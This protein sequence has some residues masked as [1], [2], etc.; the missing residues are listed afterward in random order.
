MLANR[1]VA[2]YSLVDAVPILTLPG[3]GT[4]KGYCLGDSTG[5]EIVWENTTS[6]TIQT[7]SD[8]N[9]ADSHFAFIAATPGEGAPIAVYAAVF[10]TYQR[11]STLMLGTGV[12]PNPRLTATILAAAYDPPGVSGCDFQAQAT[13]W[14]SP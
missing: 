10:P 5:A 12:A 11:G 1:I 9:Q 4:V 7:W 14:S 6:T 3:L 8:F 13:V 2:A